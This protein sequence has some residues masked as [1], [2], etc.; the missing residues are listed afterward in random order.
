MEWDCTLISGAKADGEAGCVDDGKETDDGRRYLTKDDCRRLV[1]K[2]GDENKFERKDLLR[3]G[4]EWSR[5]RPKVRSFSGGR[6]W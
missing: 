5:G 2:K 4:R 6:T 3:M 1:K